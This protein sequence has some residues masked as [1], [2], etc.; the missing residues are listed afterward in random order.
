MKKTVIALLLIINFIPLS[1]FAVSAESKD[2]LFEAEV[3]EI[4]D[5]REIKGEEGNIFIQQDLKLKGLKGRFKDDE[6]LINGISDLKV[7]KQSEYKVDD[8]VMVMY[9]KEFD[10]SND[11]YIVDYVRR[12]SLWWL[13]ILFIIIVLIIGRTKGARALGVLFLT[14]LIIL[15]F[16]IPLILSGKSPLLI[17]IIASIIILFLAIF[18][19]KGFNKQ[20]LVAFQS[21]LISLGLI[22]ILSYIFTKITFLTGVSSDEALYL[23]GFDDNIINLKGLLLAGIII[24]AL[25]VMDDVIISQVSIVNELK[26]ANPDLS[27]KQVYKQ[28]MNVGVDHI[29]AIINTLFLAYAGVSLPLLVAFSIN[30]PPFLTFSQVI[31][32]EIIATEI[33]RSFVGSIALVLSIP[34]TTWLAVKKISK[35][36]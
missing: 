28:A 12:G 16:V 13:M 27:S 17:S 11:F 25:G 29:N 36:N 26:Q 14:F 24:G 33:V 8:K 18:F 32:N 22:V 19:T 21:I 23:L 6:I 7:I 31:N 5:Q 35:T 15:K 9:S 2:E 30:E 34:I 4:V 20:S 10:G 1:V 3:L